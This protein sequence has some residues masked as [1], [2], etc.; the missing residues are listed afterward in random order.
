VTA[1]DPVT[2]PPPG[3]PRRRRSLAWRLGLLLSVAVLSV[4]LLVG[5]VVNR[6]VSST[7]ENV[8]TAQQQQRLDDAAVTLADRLSRPAG[9]AR[10][11]ALVTR[12]ATSLGGEVRVIGLDGTTLAAFGR[13][14]AGDPAHYAVPI[15]G[16]SG[17]VATLEADLPAQAVTGAS[18]AFNVTLLIAGSSGALASRRVDRRGLTR[19]PRRRRRRPASRGGRDGCPGDGWRRPGVD[20]ARRGVQRDGGPPRTLGDASAAGGQRHRP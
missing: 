19:P 10:A 20:R 12:I 13:A 14:P 3:A 9:L 2:L 15:E 4:L 5:I 11:Q 1:R 6:V 17:T 18:A 7:F 16:D 8:L